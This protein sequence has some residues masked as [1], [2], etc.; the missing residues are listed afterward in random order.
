MTA[1]CV[2]IYVKEACP[3]S[4]ALIH[5]LEQDGVDYV[6]YDVDRDGARLQEMLALNGGQRAVPTVVWPDRGVE[7]GFH[8]Q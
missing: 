6:R 2:T 8:G 4:Q 3:Y 5:K 7:V 1:E